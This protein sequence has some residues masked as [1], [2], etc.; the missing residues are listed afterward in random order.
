[1]RESVIEDDHKPFRDAGIPALN[2]IDFNYGG[3]AIEHQQNWH[4]SRDQ[5][6]LVCAKSLEAVG[7]VL[8]GALPKI[9]AE[10]SKRPAGRE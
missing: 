7:E 2:L 5:I 8:L 10:L 1:M 6:D 9:D 4:T 3:G